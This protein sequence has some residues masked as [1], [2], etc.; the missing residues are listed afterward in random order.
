MYLQEAFLAHMESD[1][2]DVMDFKAV[3][4]ALCRSGPVWLWI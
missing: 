2:K 4:V 3:C 1:H